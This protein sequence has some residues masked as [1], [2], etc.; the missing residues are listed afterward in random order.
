MA[1]GKTELVSILSEKTGSTNK[2]ASQFIDA[3]LET[4]SEKLAAGERVQLI[5]FGTFMTRRSEARQGRNPGTGEK[6]SI[7]AKTVP[8]FKPGRGLKDRVNGR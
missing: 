8:A 2:Q 3:F 4:V 5:G 1:T 7:P 6:I